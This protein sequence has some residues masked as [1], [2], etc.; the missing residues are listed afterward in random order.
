MVR[1]RCVRTVGYSTTALGLE[2]TRGAGAVQHVFGGAQSLVP[3][4]RCPHC[5]SMQ[6][7][8]MAA[9]PLPFAPPLPPCGCRD[10]WGTGLLANTHTVQYNTSLSSGTITPPPPTTV[11]ASHTPPPHYCYCLSYPP[12][13]L[14]L[15]PL[16][17][18]PPTAVTA[19]HTTLTP[20][21]TV[22]ASHTTLTPPHYC[23]RLSCHPRPPHYCYCLS[24]HP[25]PPHYCYCLSYHPHPPHYCHCHS[26]CHCLSYQ[27]HPPLPQTTVTASQTT[28]R[29]PPPQLL[30]LPPKPPSEGTSAQCTTAPSGL[31]GLLPPTT[32]IKR[33]PCPQATAERGRGGGGSGTRGI[34]GD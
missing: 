23:Y 17:P 1:A 20:L 19:S 7:W 13:P 12:P 18:P 6:L 29:P 31:C 9:L 3:C 22:T 4:L 34:C 33:G 11:T 30:S 10:V 25:H 24:Y 5:C 14:L 28:L 26:Y 32:D 15:L 27:P 16:I 21:T 2:R 8:P